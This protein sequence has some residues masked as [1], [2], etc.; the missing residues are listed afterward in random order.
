MLWL[1]TGV[2]FAACH[3]GSTR[4][5]GSHGKVWP[6]GEFLLASLNKSNASLHLDNRK[7]DKT[8][9]ELSLHLRDIF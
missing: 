7:S 3:E 8:R 9:H 1:L 2:V 4:S 5:D 6:S